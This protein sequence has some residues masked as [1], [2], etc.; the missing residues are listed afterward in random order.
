M[1]RALGLVRQFRKAVEM[2]QI[3]FATEAE[4]MGLFSK[5]RNMKILLVDDDEWIRDSL[6]VFFEAEGCH[7]LALETA[8]EALQVLN[9]QSYDIIIS[10]YRLPGMDGLELLSRIGNSHP[11]AMKVLFIAYGNTDVVCEASSIGIDRLIQKPF[12]IEVIKESIAQLMEKREKK[13]H[14]LYAKSG[15][16]QGLTTV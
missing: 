5:L 3:L 11:H 15:S 12:T 14:H 13:N 1:L 7:L 8:E 16:Q 10:D 4:D 9:R 2:V 6:S